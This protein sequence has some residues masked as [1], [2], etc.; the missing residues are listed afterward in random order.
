MKCGKY[1][2]LVAIVSVL[3]PL[4]AL[5]KDANKGEMHLLE[6]ARVGTTQLQPGTYKVEWNGDGPAVQVNIMQHS[7]TVATTSAKLLTD[8]RAARQDAVVLKQMNDGSHEK[9]ITEIDF[10]SRK[11]ALLFTQNQT[12]TR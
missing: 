11:E 5:A 1:L 2:I 4:S 6:T 12:A 8:D 7:R 9:T 3:L 10:G